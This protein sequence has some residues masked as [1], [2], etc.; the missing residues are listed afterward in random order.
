MIHNARVED[1]HVF[2]KRLMHYRLRWCALFLMIFVIFGCYFC[3]DN[4]SEL[5]EKIQESFQVSQTQ[6]SLLYSA[7]SMPNMIVP[8]CGGLVLGKIGK[9][10]GLFIFSTIITIG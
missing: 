5:E 6:Y 3:Y 10:W 9:G 2:S 4:P 7:Y 8:V 1:E